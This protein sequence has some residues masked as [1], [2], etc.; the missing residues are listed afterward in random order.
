MV[1][2]GGSGGIQRKALAAGIS[3]GPCSA[4]GSVHQL[5]QVLGSLCHA[6]FLPALEPCMIG[7]SGFGKLVRDPLQNACRYF[8]VARNTGRKERKSCKM[9]VCSSILQSICLRKQ[10]TRPTL[11]S[12]GEPV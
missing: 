10:H 12:Q 5:G 11:S 7:G 3:G 9:L 2:G 1:V 6:V 4:G 8:T